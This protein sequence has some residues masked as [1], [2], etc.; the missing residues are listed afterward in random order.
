MLG[1]DRDERIDD[2]QIDNNDKVIAP[3]DEGNPTADVVLAFNNFPAGSIYGT[4]LHDLLEWQFERGWPI[5]AASPSLAMI[6][7]W[8]QCWAERQSA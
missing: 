1:T 6:S 2:A 3:M 5:A 7:E 8:E 4:L